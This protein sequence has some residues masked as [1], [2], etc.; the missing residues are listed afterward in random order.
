[1]VE[2]CVILVIAVLFIC[3]YA[4]GR[5]KNQKREE[6]LEKE[7]DRKDEEIDQLLVLVKSLEKNVDEPVT[8][9]KRLEKRPIR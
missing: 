1:M 9:I 6:Y 2:L 4:V 8:S 7:L 3:T 5:Y